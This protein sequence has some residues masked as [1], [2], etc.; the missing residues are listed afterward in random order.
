MFINVL[1]GNIVKF[2]RVKFI[3]FS[4]VLGIDIMK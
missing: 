3:I 2:L 1:Y 4:S